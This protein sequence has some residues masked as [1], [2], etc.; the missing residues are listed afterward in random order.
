MLS[1]ASRVNREY[2]DAKCK[3]FGASEKALGWASRKSQRL[4]YTVLSLS[5]PWDEEISV[6]DVGCGQGDFLQF[7]QDENLPCR[8]TGMDLSEEMLAIARRQHPDGRFLQGD[9]LD[10]DFMEGFDYVMAS[11]LVNLRV[12]D[13][14]G[15]LYGLLDKSFSLARRGVAFNMLSSFVPEDERDERYF[16]YYDP[17]SV[18]AYCLTLTPFVELKQSYLPHDFTVF[19][20]PE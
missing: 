4:R 16:Y 18:L 6:L 1:N 20:Y 10:G 3:K 15:W 11:G 19:L 5:A 7:L 2:F 13:Q 12:S 14:M 9:F 17:L 8:Y